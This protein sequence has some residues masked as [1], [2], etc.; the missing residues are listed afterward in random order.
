MATAAMPMPMPMP[1]T[2]N[3]KSRRSPQTSKQQTEKSIPLERLTT[4]QRQ[5]KNEIDEI[6]AT[7]HIDHWKVLEY[8]TLMRTKVLK[9]S[10]I[11]LINSIVI[12][13]YTLV[14][15]LLASIICN[16][17]FQPPHDERF[18]YRKFW[19]KKRFRIFV[20]DL[21]DNIYL[22]NKRQVV[23]DIEKLPKEINSLIGAISD[24][25]NAI[26]H[27]FFPEN[28]RQFNPHKKVNYKSL[29]L[30]TNDGAQRFVEDTHLVI[31]HLWKIAFP[32]HHTTSKN[33]SS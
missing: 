10:K 7:I 26:A 16:Y 21:L 28:R 4:N 30:Y 15:D 20:Q 13:Q 17:Y 27:S 25:R 11:H 5:L 2:K 23:N 32:R 6:A 14:D 18:R 12:S 19:R 22:L 3:S 29:D 1:Q 31:R 24:I 33:S 8:P 9:L